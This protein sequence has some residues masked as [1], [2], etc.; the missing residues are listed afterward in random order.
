MDG[1]WMVDWSMIESSQV[2]TCKPGPAT[3][4]RQLRQLHGD[5]RRSTRKKICLQYFLEILQV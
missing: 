3:Q 4:G 1:S 5:D 2:K